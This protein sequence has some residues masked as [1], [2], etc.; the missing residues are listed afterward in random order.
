MTYRRAV[1][2]LRLELGELLEAQEQ[3][4][5][6][7]VYRAYDG[8][9]V[10]FL[11]EVLRFDPWSRQEDIANTLEHHPL[12]AV[13]GANAVGKDALL[14]H[15][16]LYWALARGGTALLI[17][18]TERQNVQILMRE[19]R[20]CW[21][22]VDGGLPGRLLV[23]AYEVG[24]GQP[25]GILAMTSTSVSRLTGFH[26]EKVLMI[27][28]EAQDLEP[29][30]LEAALSCATGPEDRIVQSGNPL[31][32]FGF[33][34]DAAR[35]D[36]WATVTIPAADHPNVL[37]GKTVIPGGPSKEGI[38]RIRDQYGD[39]SN[40][41]R[42]RVL[43]EFPTQDAEGLLDR[44]WIDA[45]VERFESKAMRPEGEPTAGLDVAR[46][47]AD[48]NCLII[49]AGGYVLHMERWG[50]LSTQNTAR[51]AAQIAQR[52]GIRPRSV[53]TFSPG[54]RGRFV[55]DVVGLGAGCAEK[56]KELG[57][58]VVE[59][60][61]GAFG[62]GRFLNARAESFWRLR[63]LLG[64]DGGKIAFPKDSRLIEELLALRW[65]ESGGGKVQIGEKSEIKARIGR[66]PDTAD[67]L[68]LAFHQGPARARGFA[69]SV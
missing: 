38:E 2:S 9:P 17:S 8:R 24:E 67:A 3:V 32:P 50:G 33:F 12:V 22:R 30:V 51:K 37:E 20:G 68:A 43:S 13:V 16:A 59:H 57:Y 5:D 55:V 44:D 31:H 63:E 40:T 18:P 10:D 26:G 39:E 11:R 21:H 41:Y 60:N 1:E 56:L 65:R 25:G 36:T 27:L 14:A 6:L 19:I 7:S 34:H 48:G 29:F 47:G 62:N 64:P 15:Y 46:Y 28:S 35:G 52:W 4:R 53:S 61:G 49:Q 54:K 42:S 45:A 58:D 69:W 66:S 23:N